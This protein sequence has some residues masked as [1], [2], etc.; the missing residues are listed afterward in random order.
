MVEK[1]F[2]TLFKHWIANNPPKKAAVYELKLE[3]TGRLSFDRVYDHQV[4]GLRQAKY[5][6]VYHKIADQPAAWV[7]GKR[8]HFGG[9]KPF[10]CLFLKNLEAYVVVMFYVPFEKKEA[11]F[12]DID[13][14]V[15]EKET[16]ERKSLTLERAKEIAKMT[17]LLT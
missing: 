1:D 5:K 8:V 10:D 2:Q 9:K 15:D 3:K 16:S 17:V 7:G 6:G 4:A 12:I 13:R 11:I 14:W